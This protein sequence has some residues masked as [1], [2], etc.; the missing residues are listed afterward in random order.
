MLTPT[1][2]GVVADDCCAEITDPVA[3]P[4]PEAIATALARVCF[5][6]DDSAYCKDGA[7]FCKPRV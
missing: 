7:G 2:K 5:E 1:S 3:R 6:A 4:S